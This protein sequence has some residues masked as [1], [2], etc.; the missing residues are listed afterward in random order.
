MYSRVYVEITNV[1]NKNCSFCA[2]HARAPRYMSETEF[3]TV[4][5]KLKG[6]T[7]YVYYHLMGE[8]T[9]HPLLPRFI[10]MSKG[11]GYKSVVTTNGSLL[12]R[13]G[14][15]IISAGVYKVNISVHSFEGVIGDEYERYIRSCL[16]FADT[17]SRSGVLVI[18][19]LWNSGYDGGKNADILRIMKER[20]ADREWKNV[21]NGARIR[22]RLHIE[23]GE[24]FAWPD[25][26][27]ADG[28]ETVFCYG[29][30][31]HFSVL[32]DGTVV[33]C[34]LDRNADIALGNIFESDISEI[35]SSPRA[36]AVRNAFKNNLAAEELCRK[37]GYARQKFSRK[38]K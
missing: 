13:V 28:G 17:A 4:T 27:A 11:K 1:C 38:I 12:D 30:S 36:C 18:L 22:H 33:P 7:E 16:D 14:C 2:G 6:I 26:Q 25:I 24:R 3:D 5:D 21:A 10:A 8:P 23:Y 9:L 29:L 35:L 37:C 15:D 19:R 34:C 32:C 31:D 20:F